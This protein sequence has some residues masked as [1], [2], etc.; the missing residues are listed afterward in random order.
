[1][2]KKCQ[3]R[4]NRET[5]TQNFIRRPTMVG[6]TFL[7]NSQFKQTPNFLKSSLH[8][9]VAMPLKGSKYLKLF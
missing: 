6:G 5:R 1:M 2:K 9:G 7:G 4:R 8:P 3:N